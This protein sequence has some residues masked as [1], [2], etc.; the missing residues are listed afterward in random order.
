MLE[1]GDGYIKREKFIALQAGI[2]IVFCSS[3]VT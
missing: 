1:R 3:A 2:D